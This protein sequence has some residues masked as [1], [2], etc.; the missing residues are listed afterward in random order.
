MQTL[1]LADTFLAIEKANEIGIVKQAGI[2]MLY[3]SDVNDEA[4]LM[5]KGADNLLKL[6]SK[7]VMYS[8]LFEVFKNSEVY[9]A[10]VDTPEIESGLKGIYAKMTKKGKEY[11]IFAVNKL[12]VSSPFTL[13]VDG[14]SYSGNYVLENY[15][16]DLSNPVLEVNATSNQWT[17]SNMAGA[18]SL[19][20]TSISIITIS[21]TDLNSTLST[22]HIVSSFNLNIY[23]IPANNIL[24]IE[25][26]ENSDYKIEILDVFTKNTIK[27]NKINSSTID[28]NHL[29]SGV[30][31]LKITNDK[32][33]VLIKK[34]IKN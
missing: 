31:I 14:K 11:K 17:T 4:T 33:E 13:N 16:K 19:P 8:K 2:H 15:S 18:I 28:I 25:G 27:F 1:G 10:D 3:K 20:A 26:L 12:P 21:E 34:L 32:N 6:T 30:Y 22:Q 24:H 9:N 5:F 29:A 7:G 23:P